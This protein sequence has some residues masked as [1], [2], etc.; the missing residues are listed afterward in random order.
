[1]QDSVDWVL[2]IHIEYGF[3]GFMVLLYIYS[4]FAIK[5]R[6]AGFLK[7]YYRVSMS[8]W[9]LGLVLFAVG[10]LRNPDNDLPMA[11][12][13]TNL[14]IGLVGIVLMI[15]GPPMFYDCERRIRKRRSK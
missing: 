1:M 8:L 12:Q 7:W 3:L 10:M 14:V 9:V 4:W 5:R 6:F 11:E 2:I 13:N 15:V